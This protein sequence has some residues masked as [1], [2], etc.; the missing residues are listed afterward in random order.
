MF[1][2][3]ALFGCG[4]V[5]GG[6][7][8]YLYWKKK[9]ISFEKKCEE[10][11]QKE[12]EEIKKLRSVSGSVSSAKEFSV[13]TKVDD[14]PKD[15]INEE[16][17]HV[18]VLMPTS[19]K[20]D[21][22]KPIINYNNIKPNLDDLAEKYGA[23]MER[24]AYPSEVYTSD[25]E[26]IEYDTYSDGL[27][28]GYESDCLEYYMINDILVTDNGEEIYNDITE[29]LGVDCYNIILHQ[30]G[31]VYIVNH[32]LQMV[33]EVVAKNEYYGEFEENMN[34]EE[35]IDE[36]ELEEKTEQ[37]NMMIEEGSTPYEKHVKRKKVEQ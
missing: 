6:L 17:N 36:K 12:L 14:N 18:Q 37:Y 22:R 13:E 8:G 28:L 26:I 25:Y 34:E 29:L 2:N 30:E 31:P 23:N 15:I 27:P 1:K 5:I 21:D 19:F 35:G 32:K 20:K 10:Q 33:Y 9:T 4:V 7:S 16:D 24:T 11:V 3:I